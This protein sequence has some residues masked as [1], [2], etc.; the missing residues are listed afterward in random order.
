M[1]CLEVFI[2]K[3]PFE[4]IPLTNFLQSFLARVRLQL[5]N[6]DYCPHYLFAL[7]KKCWATNDVEPL[8]FPII[9]QMLVDCKAKVLKH[10]Y[11][12]KDNYSQNSHLVDAI[13]TNCIQYVL[14]DDNNPCARESRASF[15]IEINSTR[16]PCCVLVCD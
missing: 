16:L 9:I 5:L 2:G 15:M 8:Q 6:V 13:D 10:P 3:L 1:L 14:E 11:G 7:I 12:Q 4:D